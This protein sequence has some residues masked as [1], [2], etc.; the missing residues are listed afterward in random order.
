MIM[1]KS[2]FYDA[3]WNDFTSRPENERT[4]SFIYCYTRENKNI[5][6]E[7]IGRAK[8]SVIDYSRRS[9]K[10][11]YILLRSAYI[12]VGRELMTEQDYAEI[13]KLL[14]GKKLPAKYKCISGKE[15]VEKAEERFE[16]QFLMG[17]INDYFYNL[18]YRSGHNDEFGQITKVHNRQVKE[19]GYN[20][21]FLMLHEFNKFTDRNGQNE[22]AGNP[23]HSGEI[24]DEYIGKCTE[25]YYSLLRDKQTNVFVPLHIDSSTGAGIYIIGSERFP[26]DKDKELCHICIV[27]FDWVDVF[28]SESEKV[29]DEIELH[30]SV[31]KSYDSVPRAFKDFTKLQSNQEFF[32]RYPLENDDMCPDGIDDRFIPYFI[33]RED[34]ESRRRKSQALIVKNALN[35]EAERIHELEIRDKRMKTSKRK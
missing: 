21:E 33:P 24:T 35:K 20:D 7:V 14:L 12:A 28:Q 23:V 25:L 9:K 13:L 10:D 3:L 29:A 4:N 18:G 34:I 6:A 22:Q 19:N 5:R 11:K 8:E 31:I 2:D 17:S 26:M 1:S 27:C 15:I 16:R 32:S 30:T